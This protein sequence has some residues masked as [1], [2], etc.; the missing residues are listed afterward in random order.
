MSV[1]KVILRAC[2]STLAAVGVLLVFMFA[3]LCAVFPSTMMVI[4][5]DMGMESSSIHFAERAYKDSDDIYYIAYATEV[6]IE[7]DNKEKIVSCGE[8]MI[9]DSRFAT[10][11]QEEKSEGYEQFIYGEICVAQYKNG[12][13]EGALERAYESLQGGFPKNNALVAVMMVAKYRTDLTMIEW[14]LEK[15][16]TIEVEG[17]EKSYLDETIAFFTMVE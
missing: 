7:D 10:Y 9:A 3:T 16:E 8:K 15:L 6:A 17:E 4:A 14:G 13:S 12:D 5:Y 2:L 1:D 11:T